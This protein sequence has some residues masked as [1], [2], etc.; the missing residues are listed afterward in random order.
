[1][2]DV[3]GMYER[4]LKWRRDVKGLCQMRLN[5]PRRLAKHAVNGVQLPWSGLVPL[6]W[7][8]AGGRRRD[9]AITSAG[10]S[11]PPHPQVSWVGSVVSQTVLSRQGTFL[12]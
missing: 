8:F 7:Q 5:R 4:T 1:M 2:D 9:L 12:K 3:T 11:P 6:D 10:G